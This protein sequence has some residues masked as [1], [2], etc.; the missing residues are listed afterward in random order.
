MNSS[1]VSSWGYPD[2]FANPSEK[3]KKEWLLQYFKAAF[4]DYSSQNLNGSGLRDQIITNRKYAAGKQDKT[5][6]AK[7]LT[8]DGDLSFSKLN[9]DLTSPLPKIV[10]SITRTIFNQRFKPQAIPVDPESITDADKH[11][12]RL[13]ANMIQ[14]KTIDA[15][16]AEIGE[17]PITDASEK[18]PQ[19]EQEIQLEMEINYKSAKSIAMD[20]LIA[21]GFMQNDFDQ[22]EEKI[23]RDLVV[24][25]RAITKVWVDGDNKVRISYVDPA[26][27][28]SSYVVKDDFSDARHLGEVMEMSINELKL[29]GRE[30]S[31]EEIM[32][33]AKSSVSR[34]GKR[35]EFG[36]KNYYDLSNEQRSSIGKYKVMVMHLEIFQVD[37]VAYTSKT[38]KNGMKFFEKKPP[39]YEPKNKS[40]NRNV[41]KGGIET[42]YTGYWV[43]DTDVM[44]SWG[45]KENILRERKSGRFSSKVIMG[46]VAK[47]PNIYDMHN[48]SKVEQAIHYVDLIAIT[49]LKIAQALAK[50][51]PPGEALDVDAAMNVIRKLDIQKIKTPLDLRKLYQETGL[52][53]TSSV[54]EDGSLIQNSHSFQHLPSGIDQNLLVLFDVKRR[55]IQEMKEDLGINDAVDASQPD[56]DALVGVQKMAAE[57]HRESLSGLINAY[58]Y[59]VKETAKRVAYYYQML[60]NAGDQSVISELKAAIGAG[61]VEA[62][63]MSKLTKTDFSIDVEMLPTAAEEEMMRQKLIKY[64]SEGKIYPEAEDMIMRVAKTSLRKASAL[65]AFESKR[66][67]EEEYLKKQESLK[68]QSEYQAQA[69][70]ALEREKQQTIEAEL[71]SKIML[72]EAEY[73]LK[74]QYEKDRMDLEKELETVKT[75]GKKEVLELNHN[76]STDKNAA[77]LGGRSGYDITKDSIPR[78]AGKIE[79]SIGLPT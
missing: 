79:P 53:L 27:F 48:G 52:L 37:K 63:E 19:S 32:S 22:I 4:S 17:L 34:Y 40:K 56:K 31:S 43:V 68:A 54:R 59:V 72:L 25:N 28:V 77:I 42:V 1:S 75:D 47:A 49:D 61:N 2:D 50:A 60:I 5:Q 73:R 26:N 24:A 58:K 57:A 70:I 76:L 65:M 64:V 20:Y 55:Y 12:R 13:Y 78:E 51:A 30:L 7:R 11:R 10:D 23:A 44:L 69:G 29:F 39:N 67:R 74:T 66:T 8:T 38:T 18:I 3:K 62:I 41:Y 46:Y 6:Y 71:E 15:H 33:I 35:W 9:F 16:L 21:N 36:S 45:L 14:S